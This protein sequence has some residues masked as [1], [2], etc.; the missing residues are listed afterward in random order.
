G[1]VGSQT[2]YESAAGK[3][4]GFDAHGCGQAVC[5]PLWRGL[6]GQQSI[7]DSSPTVA[8]G[9]VYVGAFDHRLYAFDA[10]GCGQRRC[11]PLWT[12]LTGGTIESTPTAVGDS[13]LV[14]SDDGN[15]YAFPAAGC[16]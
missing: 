13:I 10:N 14:G 8:G 11:Q 9:V 4:N 6:A 12:G 16:G 15:L 7:L 5:K 2:S 3:L 1:Y